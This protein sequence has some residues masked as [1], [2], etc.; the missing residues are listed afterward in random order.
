MTG[1]E[2]TSPRSELTTIDPA[3]SPAVAGAV[4][5][6]VT[7]RLWPGR[8]TTEADETEPNESNCSVATR[9]GTA[10]FVPSSAAVSP[11]MTPVQVPGV[12]YRTSTL[13]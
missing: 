10:P 8:S 13:P 5:R 1:T 2:V 4:A 12:G 9:H 3:A 7:V 6:T 11:K